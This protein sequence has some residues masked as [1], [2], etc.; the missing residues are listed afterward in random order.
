[1]GLRRITNLL[2]RRRQR[3]RMSQQTKEQEYQ[4]VD[5]DGN[6]QSCPECGSWDVHLI[7]FTGDDDGDEFA[8]ANFICYVCSATEQFEYQ[9]ESDS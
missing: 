6:H 7:P 1:M 9:P 8:G 4:V 3:M 2:K 5:V